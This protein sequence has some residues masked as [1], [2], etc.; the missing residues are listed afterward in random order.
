[1][2]IPDDRELRDDLIGPEY[3]FT[4]S[5]QIQLEKKE[6]MKKRGLQSPDCGDALALTFA[7]SPC[8]LDASRTKGWRARLN[9]MNAASSQAA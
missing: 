8:D 9:R 5:N 7:V 1:M 4:A 2:E 6:D 3:G